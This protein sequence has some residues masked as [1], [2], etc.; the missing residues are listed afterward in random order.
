MLDKPRFSVP[1]DAV[2]EESH[3]TTTY[4]R[5]FRSIRSPFALQS[6]SCGPVP[7]YQ[8][9]QPASS[10]PTV[11][12]L[13]VLDAIVTTTV[14]IHSRS[15]SVGRPTSRLPGFH[16]AYELHT[17]TGPNWACVLLWFVVG[18]VQQPRSWRPAFR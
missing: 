11:Q 4:W 7:V 5:E 15:L 14:V 18:T 2:L 9:Q 8:Q 17:V 1:D 3:S 13:L 12:P 10:Q 6:V 16:L